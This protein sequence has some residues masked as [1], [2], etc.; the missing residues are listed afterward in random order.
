MEEKKKIAAEQEQFLQSRNNTPTFTNNYSPTITNKNPTTK[1]NTSTVDASINRL[2]DDLLPSK[3]HTTSSGMS[4]S[5]ANFDLFG[6]GKGVGSG[7]NAFSNF[8]QPPTNANAVKKRKDNNNSTL[9]WLGEFDGKSGS[10]GS[11]TSLFPTSGGLTMNNNNNQSMP[12][13][14]KF[15]PNFNQA[16][17]N[18]KKEDSTTDP[19][20]DLLR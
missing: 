10:G 5:A 14:S 18:P 17:V 20:M 1:N 11:S 19:F 6:S 12:N 9:N 2:L 4:N 3:G 8:P 7:D 16:F 15:Q 13:F